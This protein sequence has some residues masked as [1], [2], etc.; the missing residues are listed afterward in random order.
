MIL[1]SNVEILFQLIT[2]FIY[3]NKKAKADIAIHSLAPVV[4]KLWPWCIMKPSLLLI[5]LKM[6][7]T[8]SHSCEQG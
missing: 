6:V 5:T 4:H 2:N 1:L 3:N 7:S 8:F